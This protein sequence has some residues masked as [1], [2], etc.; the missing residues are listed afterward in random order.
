M[1]LKYYQGVLYK[2]EHPVYVPAEDSFLLL[3]EVKCQGRV[4]EIGTG[5]GLI[6]IYFAKL[7]KEVDAVD[8]SGEALDCASRNCNL[9]DVRINLVQSDLFQNIH[10]KYDTIIFNPPYLPTSDDIEGAEAWNGG[11]DG[12]A[13]IRR[14]LAGA[15]SHLADNGSIYL[16][17]SDLTDIRS[18]IQEFRN[19]DFLLLGSE[20]FETET[21][22]AYRLT[23][24]R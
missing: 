6:A 20:H 11:L 23:L 2:A 18:L 22:H 3:R 15:P 16:I 17:L 5:S 8:I 13:V 9:N 21:I 4:L 10:G 12:F 19:F 14:F 7:G 24:G 1:P